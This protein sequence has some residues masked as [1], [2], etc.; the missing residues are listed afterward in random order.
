[1]QNVNLKTLEDIT[2]ENSD[3]TGLAM[4]FKVQLQKHGPWMKQSKLDYV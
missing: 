1:M 4:T 3:D 2:E